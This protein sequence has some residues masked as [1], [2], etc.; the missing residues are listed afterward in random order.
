MVSVR[1]LG[2]QEWALGDRSVSLAAKAAI[3]AIREHLAPLGFVE[4]RNGAFRTRSLPRPDGSQRSGARVFSALTDAE[5]DALARTL[6]FP[7]PERSAAEIPRTLRDFYAVANGME[8][9]G[10][11]IFGD[12]SRVEPAAAAPVGLYY[13]MIERPPGTPKMHFGFGAINGAWAAQGKLY[14]AEDGSVDFRHGDTGKV[15]ARWPSFAAFLRQEVTRQLRVHD[16]AGDLLPGEEALP[17]DCQDWEDVSKAL[18]E[19]RQ[20]GTLRDRV[21]GRLRKLLR[22]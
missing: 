9:F 14:L 3:E 2:P 17:G 20:R 10:L 16:L 19:R 13:G 1:H 6:P 8:L 11:A 15:G 7:V 22:L 18:A 4:G 21:T 12:Y 5:M